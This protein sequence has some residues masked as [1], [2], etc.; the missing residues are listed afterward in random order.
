METGRSSKA[1]VIMT[2][3]VVTM[4]NACVMMSNKVVLVGDRLL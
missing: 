4:G 1:K 3:S 2:D